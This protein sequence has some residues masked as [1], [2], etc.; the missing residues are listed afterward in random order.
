MRDTIKSKE[1][2]VLNY[3]S[4]RSTNAAAES[5][6]SKIKGLRAQVHGV[7]DLPFFMF[8]CTKIFG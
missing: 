3:F 6:N 7:C 2:Y 4:N 1:E 5:F 8:R